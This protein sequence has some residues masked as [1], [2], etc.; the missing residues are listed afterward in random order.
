MKIIK[1]FFA[2]PFALILLVSCA[3]S[4]PLKEKCLSGKEPKFEGAISPISIP[5]KAEYKP[6]RYHLES[7]AAVVKIKSSLEVSTVVTMEISAMGDSLLWD[8]KITSTKVD[9]K[10]IS[11]A[12]PLADFRLLTKKNGEVQESEISFPALEQQGKY[13]DS[14]RVKYDEFRDSLREQVKRSVP[15]LNPNPIKTGDWI[16]RAY[17]EKVA[18]DLIAQGY[19]YYEGQKVIVAA[20]DYS[21]DIEGAKAAM[22]GYSLLDPGTFHSIRMEALGFFTSQGEKLHIYMVMLAKRF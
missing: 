10:D 2:L 11:T 6:A 19:S 8:G 22:K 3:S 7:S 17:L 14:N 18:V 1:C 16:H 21:G 13:A 5:I 4:S 12:L 9:G 20:F 15:T